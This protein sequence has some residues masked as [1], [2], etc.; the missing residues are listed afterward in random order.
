[1]RFITV[2]SVTLPIDIEILDVAKKSASGCS[3]KYTFTSVGESL[4]VLLQCNVVS[5]CS[6][7]S[8]QCLRLLLVRACLLQYD[9]YAYGYAGKV[10]HHC[11]VLLVVCYSRIS[12]HA[13]HCVPPQMHHPVYCMYREVH[14]ILHPVPIFIKV[15]SVA[16]YRLYTALCV[17]VLVLIDQPVM[18]FE[19]YF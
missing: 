14:C 2:T 8:I 3:H 4:Q 9:R 6:A 7:S 5:T 15:S 18:Q 16:V 1:M 17:R 13:E 11:Q 12:C 19:I 10:I